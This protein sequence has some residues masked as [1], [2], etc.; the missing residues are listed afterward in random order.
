MRVSET[1]QTSNF[2][3]AS[4]ITAP[5]ILTIRSV[6]AQQLK[7]GKT[8]LALSFDEIEQVLL[9]NRTNAAIVADA[10]GD[11]ANEWP[12]QKIKLVKSRTPFQGKMVDSIRVETS[13]RVSQYNEANPPPAEN[14]PDDLNDDVPF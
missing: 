1:Y 8:K 7:D 4:D 11:E 5:K 13:R 12:G 14:I 6:A 9:L 3:R 2:I 10:Y